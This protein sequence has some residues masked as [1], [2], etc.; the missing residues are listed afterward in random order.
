[1]FTMYVYTV[2]D[3]SSLAFGTTIDEGPTDLD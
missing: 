3:V 1:M 2:A